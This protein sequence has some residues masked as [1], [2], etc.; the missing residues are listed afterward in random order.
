MN[1]DKVI[2]IFMHCPT[3]YNI[4]KIKSVEIDDKN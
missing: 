2:I 1:N 3:L 4:L